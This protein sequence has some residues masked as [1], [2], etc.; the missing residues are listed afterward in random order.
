M[1]LRQR[2]RDLAEHILKLGPQD[3]VLTFSFRSRSVSLE[4]V[5]DYAAEIVAR[6]ILVSDPIGHLVRPQ[7][8]M[9]LAARRNLHNQDEFQDLVAPEAQTL[10][11]TQ[12]WSSRVLICNS[13]LHPDGPPIDTLWDLTC[14]EWKARLVMPDPLA[15]SVQANVIQTILQHPDEMAA[16]YDD[17]IV[18]ADYV[19]EQFAELIVLVRTGAV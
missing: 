12:R 14:P 10:L 1:E 6:S 19:I 9:L 11:L 17:E 2:G 16:V 18:A 7:P 3:V 15:G 13:K 5:L 4:V 8:D